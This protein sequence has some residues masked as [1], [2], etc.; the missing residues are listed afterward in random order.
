MT[1]QDAALIST[2]CPHRRCR[3]SRNRPISL[4][5]N[6][7]RQHGQV[8]HPLLVTKASFTGLSLSG[9]HGSSIVSFPQMAQIVSI[10]SQ[11]PPSGSAP[12]A[13]RDKISPPHAGQRLCESSV[14]PFEGDVPKTLSKRRSRSFIRSGGFSAIMGE[15]TITASHVTVSSFHGEPSALLSHCFFD[16]PLSFVRLS[17]VLRPCLCLHFLLY[18]PEQP[19]WQHVVE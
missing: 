14:Q 17:F 3:P 10:P 16:I 12:P 19:G 1:Y 6:R 18:F 4:G 7:N 9:I 2:N 13:L 11:R 5:L 8:T 15:A